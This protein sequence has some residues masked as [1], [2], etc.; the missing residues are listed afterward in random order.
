MLPIRTILYP[1]DFS[2]LAEPALDIANALARD[3]GARLFIC[4]IMPPSVRTFHDSKIVEVSTD[5]IKAAK[6][7]LELIRPVDARIPVIHKLA[8]GDEAGEIIRVAEETKADVIVMGTHGRSG[9]S[10]LL[11]GSVAEIV[12][13]SAPCPVLTVRV[14]FTLP[15]RETPAEEMTVEKVGVS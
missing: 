8:F 11:M 7:R 9:F 2:D 4:H 3:Y 6:E 1:S 12:Q 10:R 15:L 14:P 13:R 5:S